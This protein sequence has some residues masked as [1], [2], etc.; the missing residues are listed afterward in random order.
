[1]PKSRRKRPELPPSSVTVTTAVNLLI[2]GLPDAASGPTHCFR[3]RSRTDRPVPPPIATTFM[4][5]THFVT[6]EN[7]MLKEWPQRS[8][9][10]DCWESVPSRREKRGSS[11]KASKSSSLRAWI[12][13][14]GRSLMA[15]S[16]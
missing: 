11:A 16:R 9:V 7:T 8:Y 12:R 4:P 14:W 10:K 1:M 6:L 15:A 3:P 5:C 13:F 2:D